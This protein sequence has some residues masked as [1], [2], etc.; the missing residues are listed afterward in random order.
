MVPIEH[1][2]IGLSLLILFC[3]LTQDYCAHSIPLENQNINVNNNIALDI[4]FIVDMESW[5]GKSIHQCITMAIS[6]FYALNPSYKT[7]IVVHTRDSKGDLVKVLSAVDDL[8]KNVKVQA[9]IGPEIFLQSKLLSMF[10]DKA[11]VPIFSFSSRSSK[12]FPYLFQIKS[13][14]STMAKSIA[15]LVE[16]Y[17]WRNVI[18]IHEDT[19]DGREILPYLVE[20]F[21]EN[22]IQI[23]YISAISSS[24]TLDEITDELTKLINYETTIIIVHMSPSLASNLLL[25]AKRLGMVTEEYAWIL[26][27]KSV[28][29]FRSTNF[30]VIQSLQGALGFRPLVPTSGRLHNLTTKWHNFMY[31]NYPTPEMKEVLVPAIWAY[32]TIWALAICV[33]KVGAPNN[34]P[35]LLQELLKVKFKGISGDFELSEGKVRSNG[36][37]IMNAIDNSEKRVGYWTQSQG[38][39]SGH[40][41]IN[42]STGLGHGTVIW[43][44][45]STTTPK[46]WVSRATPNTMLKIG[47]LK[48]KNFKYFMDVGYDVE[49]NVTT[50]TGFSVDVFN[51][52]IL[53]LPYE[54]PYTFVV[55]ENVSYD[56]LVQKVYKKEIDAVVGDST[57]LANRSEYVD[58]TATYTDLGVGTLARIKKEDMWFFLKALDLSLWLTAIASLILTGLVVWAIECE[59]LSSNLSRFV[60][61][62][63]LLVVLVLVTSYTATLASLLTVEQFELA[64]KGRIVGFHGGSFMK[65]LTVSNV[66]FEG[67]HKRA[68][69]S[70]EDYALALSENGDA[71]AIVDEI[72][73]IKMFLSRYSGDYALVSS[74]SITSGF[75]FIFRKGSPLVEDVSREIAKKRLDGTLGSLE[76]K[77]FENQLLFPSGNSTM[78]KALKLDRFGG[79]FIIGGVASTFALIISVLYL[80]RAKMEVQNIISLLFRRPNSSSES[81]IGKSIHRCITM[82][83]SDFYALNPSYK[84]RIVVHMRNSIGDPVKALSAV[85]HLLRKANVQ[86]IIGPETHI[87]SKFL[88][89]PSS[90]EYPYL[91]QIKQDESTMAKSIASLVNSYNWRNVI[92]VHED[93]GD[94]REILQYLAQSF[95]DKNIR[96]SY[97]SA[98]S[99]SARHDEITKELRKIMNF[100]TTVLILHMSPSLAST[101]ILIAKSLGMVSKEYAWILT[102]KTVDLLRST[103]FTVIES[104]QGA[105]GLRSYVPPSDRLH[106]LT[107]RW[108]SFFYTK[109]STLVTKE[110]VVPALWAYDTIWAL[111]ES[112]EKAGVPHNGSMLL[113]KLLKVGFK[114]ITGDFQLGEGKVISNG[115]EIINAV[116]NGERRVGYWTLSEGIK[117]A[118][119]D[120]NNDRLHPS[121]DYEAV[122]WPGGSKT[123]PKGWV[124]RAT[125]SKSLK[126]GVMRIIYSK[127]FIDITH[128][129]EKNVTTATGFSVDVFNTCIRA[130]SYEVPYT[131][132]LF[133]N[134]T[135][136]DD[137]VQKVYNEESADA[138]IAEQIDLLN[139]SRRSNTLT[140]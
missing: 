42:N 80:V 97:R 35:S 122:I 77:W 110:V 7:R 48:I 92:F 45:G 112:L 85:D 57:I 138:K 37:E 64:S 18:F 118:H 13:E 26:T 130:L 66:H 5:V 25:N 137:L 140:L 49:N 53:A 102:E 67:H 33:E 38:I 131:F 100:Q 91:F 81:W 82:A 6:N 76:N 68:Y 4:G 83:I 95:L 36:Y 47:V 99:A 69:Y 88:S 9:I 70:Y 63:W 10:A 120:I 128:D 119:P 136:Y 71:D 31:R 14:E 78:P 124:L 15:A 52:C 8:L 96:I 104:S 20:S 94:G 134:A 12:E 86:A 127:N 29:L 40:P 59:K 105:L 11:K 44:G 22:N 2:K 126:I 90:R 43:P 56:D 51:A 115:Y 73:Y 24:A 28:D 139:P 132:I 62:I 79:L 16:S 89:F 103:N 50:A 75:A 114:G 17:K 58:F 125:P 30:E 72:P 21:Q 54:V 39:R 84:T 27:E 129:V 93:T 108:Q 98:I 46:G 1:N 109:N 113:H 116:D 101:F 3:I 123:A 135:N 74:Q 117:R 106:A 107:S 23:S 65:G 55:F 87:P 121:L 111:A 19:D 61:F 32:D 34:G 41:L 133:E 60:M